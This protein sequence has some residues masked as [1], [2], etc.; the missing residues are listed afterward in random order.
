MEIVEGEEADHPHHQSLWFAHGDVSGFDFWHGRDRDERI[1]W[2]ASHKDALT[3]H[4]DRVVTTVVAHYRWIVDD[5]TLICTEERELIFGGTDEVRTI[6]VSVTLTPAGEPLV[7]G[8]TKEGTFA[9]RMHPALRVN[10]EIATGRLIN[11][12]GDSDGAAW[13]KRANWVSTSGTIDG[14]HIGVSIFEHPSNHAHPTWWH[15]RTYGLI[16]AN[17][18]GA[19]DFEK[20]AKD[21]GKLTIP[22]GENLQLRYRVVLHDGGWSGEEIDSAYADWCEE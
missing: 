19:H 14:A 6:D 8:D 10:G 22:V 16:A 12:K 13:G 20:A 15:A 2:D 18:F 3:V 7:F 9:M 21:A 5:D 4:T 17:P 1:T 11:S